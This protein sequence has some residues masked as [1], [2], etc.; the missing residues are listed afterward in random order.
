MSTS[1]IRDGRRSAWSRALSLAG[2]PPFSLLRRLAARTAAVTVP[3]WA[4]LSL[5]EEAEGGGCGGA[6]G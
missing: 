2:V 3:V 4:W 1:F 6:V 5:A